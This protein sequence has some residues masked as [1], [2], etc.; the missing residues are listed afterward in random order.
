MNLDVWGLVLQELDTKDFLTMYLISKEFTNYALNQKLNKKWIIKLNPENIHKAKQ[1]NGTCK[2]LNLYFDLN[3]WL[4]KIVTN[5]D[6]QGLTNITTLD[7]CCNNTITD[8]GI[9][10]LINITHLNLRY[11]NQITDEGIKNLTKLKRN[12]Y[13][14]TPT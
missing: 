8:E 12:P 1:L 6:I 5:E 9:R 10:G 2:M 3:L 13:S 11:N 7:L 4:N 14:R